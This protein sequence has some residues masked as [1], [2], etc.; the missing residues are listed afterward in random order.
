MGDKMRNNIFLNHEKLHLNEEWAFIQSEVHGEN[1]STKNLL[2]RELIF[3][4]QILL[5]NS[6]NKKQMEIYQKTKEF[7]LSFH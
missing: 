7:Y 1:P 3:S 2:R 6:R 4:L 5:A